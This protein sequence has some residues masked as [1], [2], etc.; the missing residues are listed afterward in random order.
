MKLKNKGFTVVELIASFVFTSV[1]TMSLF[2]I[3]ISFRD[4]EINTSVETELYAFKQRFTI[5]VEQDI[6]RYGLKEINY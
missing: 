3:V 5:T 1:L 2:S 4:K 6:Q